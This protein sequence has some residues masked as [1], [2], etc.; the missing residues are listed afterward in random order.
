MAQASD[1]TKSAAVPLLAALGCLI[2]LVLGGA[3][4]RPNLDWY[5][6]L[7]KPGFTPANA[8]FPVVWTILYAMM[9][10]A[11]W[12]AWFAPGKESDRT[13]AMVA[14]A[15]QLAI[16]VAWS[17]A[18]FALHN[19]AL[20]LGVILALIAAIVITI[21]LFDRLSRVAALLLVPYL[22]WVAF[23]TMLNVAFFLLNG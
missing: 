17:A 14:F 2:A 3:L 20:G 4:T 13:A 23:A 7:T 12:L 5:A 10:L 18:F 22:L 21:V 1:K 19:I 11:A 15:V 6:T 9:A 16:G 8:V